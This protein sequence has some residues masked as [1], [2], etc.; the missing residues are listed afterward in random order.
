MKKGDLAWLPSATSLLQFS[1]EGD[2]DS[3]VKCFCNPKA[4]THVLILGEITDVYYHIEYLR[5]TYIAW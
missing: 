3:G 1:E 5:T 2:P 4:P